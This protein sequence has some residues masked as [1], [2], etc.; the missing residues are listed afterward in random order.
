MLKKK[1]DPRPVPQ[2]C[3]DVMWGC[4]TPEYLGKYDSNLQHRGLC[5]IRVLQTIAVNSKL[6]PS[7]LGPL[8]DLFADLDVDSCL[9]TVFLQNFY[10]NQADALPLLP[11]F[12]FCSFVSGREELL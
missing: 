1:K 8:M 3:S 12:V 7:K 10:P 4:L 5:W 2:F 6:E 11:F 9:F